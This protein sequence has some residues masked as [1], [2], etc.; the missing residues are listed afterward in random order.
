MV[1][2][3]ITML[4]FQG[5]VF[6]LAPESKCCKKR[7]ASTFDKPLHLQNSALITGSGELLV[8]VCCF[9][10]VSL[11]LVYIYLR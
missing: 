4:E 8:S 1:L 6:L 9:D 7:L 3:A 2:N 10:I 5:Y 11:E